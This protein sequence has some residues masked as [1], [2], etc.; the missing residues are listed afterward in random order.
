MVKFD[1]EVKSINPAQKIPLDATASSDLENRQVM[2]PFVMMLIILVVVGGV[3]GFALY[4]LEQ[5]Q[6][7]IQNRLH[8]TVKA[9]VS[10]LR[11]GDRTQF[12]AV[13]RS[14]SPSW[15]ETQATLYE[16]YQY[17]KTQQVLTLNAEI[18]STVID[19][20]RARVQVMEQING[21]AYLQT[22]FYWNY[23]DG[24]RH[25]PTDYTFWGELKTQ[26][27]EYIN[28]TYAELDQAIAIDLLNTLEGG[29]AQVC[30]WIT[31]EPLN[32][33]LVSREGL[34][35]NWS[36]TIPNQLEVTSP[37]VER[38]ALHQPIAE[39]LMGD[40]TLQIAKHLA[41]ANGASLQT[42]DFSD[43]AFIENQLVAYIQ[44][45]LLT[46]ESVSNL[47]IDLNT[48]FESPKIQEVLQLSLQNS[49]I[50]L[51]QA[52]FAESILGEMP[53]DWSPYANWLLSREHAYW[54]IED[55]AAFNTLYLND[56]L[57]QLVAMTRYAAL[58]FTTQPY[59]G[60]QWNRLEQLTCTTL[61]AQQVEYKWQSENLY[62]VN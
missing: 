26:T 61:D 45:H 19:G 23:E 44:S 40:V 12:L 31:C 32:I 42:G 13:Q 62:R 47:F 25:V 60:C 48:H 7:T 30:L 34:S 36:V 57:S 8:E 24:W 1:W 55:S 16:D 17:L 59:M 53:I 39:T 15:L 37:Y 28:L 5:I 10:F 46:G 41:Q 33:H 11:L 2:L 21:Q 9:E 56:S 4:R 29:L 58:Q 6:K 43:R 51:L 54:D 3:I 27:G 22:W 35:V 38:V 52:L 50:P 18:V 14:A 20:N 49:F